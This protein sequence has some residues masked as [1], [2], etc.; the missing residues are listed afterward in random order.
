MGSLRFDR[1]V[2]GLREDELEAEPGPWKEIS[3]KTR[4]PEDATNNDLCVS[5]TRM[6]N[7]RDIKDDTV[8]FD[9]S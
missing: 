2:V 3:S 6:N 9:M 4:L 7:V 1:A 5:G 8:S